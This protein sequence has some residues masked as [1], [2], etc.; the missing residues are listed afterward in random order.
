M[1]WKKMQ[2]ISSDILLLD[3]TDIELYMNTKE[4]GKNITGKLFVV[5][6][7]RSNSHAQWQ[8]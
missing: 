1:K 4:M 3:S 2:H 6:K 7:N 5:T 8:D